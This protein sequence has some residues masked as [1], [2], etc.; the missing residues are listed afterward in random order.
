MAIF[1]VPWKRMMLYAP[2][3]P[4]SQILAAANPLWLRL[5][6][7]FAAILSVPWSI[8]THFLGGIKNGYF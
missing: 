1:H 2:P 3:S 7:F 6:A 8:S 5:S 4:M